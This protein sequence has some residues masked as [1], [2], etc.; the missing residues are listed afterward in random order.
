MLIVAIG[1]VGIRMAILLDDGFNNIWN[2]FGL[3][4]GV[5]LTLYWSSTLYIDD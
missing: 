3:F 2:S 5:L 4:I 1:I